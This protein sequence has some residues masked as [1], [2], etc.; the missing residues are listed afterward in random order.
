MVGLLALMYVP[1]V[2]AVNCPPVTGELGLVDL[3]ECG[4]LVDG[5]PGVDARALV[6]QVCE[7]VGGGAMPPQRTSTDAEPCGNPL[8]DPDP[9]VEFVC[10]TLGG[11]ATPLKDCV[12]D[13]ADP[14][15]I[16]HDVPVVCGS[17]PIDLCALDTA[18]TAP[19]CGTPLTPS[20]I[21]GLDWGGGCEGSLSAKSFS[22]TGGGGEVNTPAVQIKVYL[23][24]VERMTVYYRVTCG[25]TAAPFASGEY[26]FIRTVILEEDRVPTRSCPYSGLPGEDRCKTPH[27]NIG[28]AATVPVTGS[29][30]DGLIPS[31]VVADW[32]GPALRAKGVGYQNLGAITGGLPVGADT[33]VYGI[34]WSSADDGLQTVIDLLNGRA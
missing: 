33:R 1:A 5:D 24:E 20:V 31:H 28:T 4:T 19:E 34:E 21:A 3:V 16:T 27:G 25:V 13:V 8:V 12:G 26:G 10:N 9:W 15:V 30:E 2:A 32:V 17:A 14:C 29:L 11:D 23:I 18:I 22:A 6:D 7:V